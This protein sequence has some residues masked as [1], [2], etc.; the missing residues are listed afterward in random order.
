MRIV[1]SMRNAV[2]VTC[3]YKKTRTCLNKVHKGLPTHLPYIHA[4]EGRHEAFRQFPIFLDTKMITSESQ[5]S[6]GVFP[7]QT[8]GQVSN[9]APTKFWEQPQVHVAG[10]CEDPAVATTFL[11]LLQA[12]KQKATTVKNCLCTFCQLRILSRSPQTSF[13]FRDELLTYLF[14]VSPSLGHILLGC[15]TLSMM[16]VVRFPRNP[17]KPVLLG[18]Q[19]EACGECLYGVSLKNNQQLEHTVCPKLS[20]Y[21]LWKPT[22]NCD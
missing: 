20:W 2:D 22:T 9:L 6:G 14:A 12:P 19:L 4:Q 13:A 5:K 8:C 18:K 10:A 15:S 3:I 16:S 21:A 17:L 1:Q 11:S 7:P